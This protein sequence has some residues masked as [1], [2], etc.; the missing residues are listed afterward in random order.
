MKSISWVCNKKVFTRVVNWTTWNPQKYVS[1]CPNSFDPLTCC[2]C[3]LPDAITILTFF[4]RTDVVGFDDGDLCDLGGI[5]ISATIS[6]NIWI[7]RSEPLFCRV[8]SQFSL[9]N[10]GWYCCWVGMRERFLCW[11]FLCYHRRRG[12]SCIFFVVVLALR[13]KGYFPILVP[14]FLFSALNL[15]MWLWQVVPRYRKWQDTIAW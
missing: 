11:W 6:E 8:G 2:S 15:E 14:V 13:D 12:K 10:R 4:W 9:L 1:P 5:F 7:L 3:F